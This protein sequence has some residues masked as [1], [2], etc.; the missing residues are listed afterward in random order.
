MRPISV[1]KDAN[2]KENRR[3]LSSDSHLPKSQANKNTEWRRKIRLVNDFRAAEQIRDTLAK[4]QK[5]SDPQK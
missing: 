3:T 2:K 5:R 1:I 4:R